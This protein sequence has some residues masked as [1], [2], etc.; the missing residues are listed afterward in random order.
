MSNYVVISSANQATVILAGTQGAAGAI[1]TVP[2]IFTVSADIA[3]ISN[4]AV[5]A[6]STGCNYADNS[7]KCN[8]L[9]ITNSAAVSG[10]QVTIMAD[11]G[12]NG[13][14]GLTQGQ[15]VY[16]GSSGN[17]TQTVPTSGFIQQLGIATSTTSVN[18][19]IST[20]IFLA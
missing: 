4:K 12:M 16:L 19:R 2:N 15:P 6:T 10:Q 20:P 18:I 1:T 5:C 17:L 7:V 3:M 9:G 13:F 11:G 8:V 14:S